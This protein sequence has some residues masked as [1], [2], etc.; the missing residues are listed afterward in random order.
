MFPR[1]VPLDG[2]GA[3]GCLGP[4]FAAA[5]GGGTVAEDVVVVVVLEDEGAVD[6]AGAATKAAFEGAGA[7]ALGLAADDSLMCSGMGVSA[8]ANTHSNEFRI[9]VFAHRVVWI[10]CNRQSL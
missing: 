3:G 1:P 5:V 9:E 7:D 10:C 6:R 4:A 2:G 8:I